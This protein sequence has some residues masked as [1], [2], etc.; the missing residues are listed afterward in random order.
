MRNVRK[1]V[2]NRSSIASRQNTHAHSHEQSEFK[3]KA[4]KNEIEGDTGKAYAETHSHIHLFTFKWRWID[5]HQNVFNDT[6]RKTKTNDKIKFLKSNKLHAAMPPLVAS[7]YQHWERSIALVI[8]RINKKKILSAVWENQL[9]S[10]E[11]IRARSMSAWIGLSVC[12]S[13]SR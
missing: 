11:F 8:L 13:P 5:R 1:S 3:R 10:S 9:N 6:E 4:P 12:L 7:K 2:S